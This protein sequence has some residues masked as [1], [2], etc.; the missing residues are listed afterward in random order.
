MT[1]AVTQRLTVALPLIGVAFLLASVFLP[2]QFAVVARG[3]AMITFLAALVCALDVQHRRGRSSVSG[4]E[5]VPT[6]T[7][8][9]P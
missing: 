2:V 1:Q 7:K 4:P 6:M 8:P 3:L 9:M 5:L